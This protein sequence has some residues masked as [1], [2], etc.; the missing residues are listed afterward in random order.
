MTVELVD[1]SGDP[2]AVIDSFNSLFRAE[3]EKSG[4]SIQEF[5]RNVRLLADPA[6]TDRGKGAAKEQIEVKVYKDTQTLLSRIDTLFQD[7]DFAEAAAQAARCICRANTCKTVGCPTEKDIPETNRL[8][9]QGN[10]IGAAFKMTEKSPY[11]IGN[12]CTHPCRPGC[13]IEKPGDAVEDEVVINGIEYVLDYFMWRVGVTEERPYGLH[14]FNFQKPEQELLDK[15]AEKQPIRIMGA[16]PGGMQAAWRLASEGYKVEV[17]EKEGMPLAEEVAAKFS[18]ANLDFGNLEQTARN[19]GINF[20]DTLIGG[21]WT[22]GIPINKAPKDQIQAYKHMLIDM[23]VQF[24]VAE[25]GVTEGY[26]VQDL[27]DSSHAVFDG[28]GEADTPWDLGA[29]NEDAIGVGHAM[30]YLRHNN[31]EAFLWQM[32][33][34]PLGDF[35]IHK[36]AQHL[37]EQAGNEKAD[38]TIEAFMDQFDGEAIVVVGGGLTAHDVREWTAKLLQAC[39]EIK[40][41]FTMDLVAVERQ[42]ELTDTRIYGDRGWPNPPEVYED[43]ASE[44]QWEAVGGR[45]ISAAVI[46]DLGVGGNGKLETVSIAHMEL[47]NP[48]MYQWVKGERK[49]QPIQEGGADKVETVEAPIL[50]KALGFKAWMNNPPQE[51]FDLEI[52]S[53]VKVK[54]RSGQEKKVDRVI[55]NGTQ[56]KHKGLFVIGD[57]SAPKSRDV[58]SAKASANHAVDAMLEMEKD[59]ATTDQTAWRKVYD[60]GLEKAATMLRTID[61][62]R[63][64]AGIG[65]LSDEAK[66]GLPGVAFG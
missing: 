42:I 43:T 27:L 2:Q 40:P 22:T 13:T 23:G 33:G 12:L 16:G 66:S 9:A 59:G 45:K 29:E 46:N 44:R 20:D 62:T 39:K 56:T 21:V 30:P 36:V 51:A 53:K 37:W 11:L 41:E 58:V 1:S 15:H 50:L 47:K 14:H 19:L 55:L 5:S 18:E 57:R 3:I 38:F 34:R 7:P 48:E 31:Y 17:I 54:N 35:Q 52:T 25:V 60:A 28:R 32:A 26:S 6:S 64:S 10:I 8:F 63:N 24:T 65:A 4:F 49:Y 61:Q